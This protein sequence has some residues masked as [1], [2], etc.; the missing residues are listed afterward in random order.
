MMLLVQ[1]HTI[2]PHA[3]ASRGP[4][5]SRHPLKMSSSDEQRSSATKEQGQLPPDRPRHR[6]CAHIRV[7]TP[8]HLLAIGM[9]D[10]GR[11]GHSPEPSNQ[12]SASCFP[13]SCAARPSADSASPSPPAAPELRA[14]S[15]STDCAQLRLCQLAL[16]SISAACCLTSAARN[17]GDG[18]VEE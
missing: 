1:H 10:G 12:A 15:S 13:C 17:Y 9:G 6:R 16:N 11:H 8:S 7:W 18:A 5:S 3:C 2:L 4:S 14:R